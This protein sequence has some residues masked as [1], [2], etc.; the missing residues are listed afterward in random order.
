MITWL[1]LTE[2]NL[3]LKEEAT[4]KQWKRWKQSSLLILNKRK[5]ITE[6]STSAASG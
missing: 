4:E 1:D 2:S 3:C 5:F 6:A